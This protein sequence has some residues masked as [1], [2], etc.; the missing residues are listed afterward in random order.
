M[1]PMNTHR[2]PSLRTQKA[3]NNNR[4]SKSIAIQRKNTSAAEGGEANEN[5]DPTD[6]DFATWRMYNRIINHRR[7]HP[8]PSTTKP[9]IR[10]GG[11]HYSSSR[12]LRYD[13]NARPL[14]QDREE[15]ERDDGWDSSRG[16]EADEE[17]IFEM[18]L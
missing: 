18:D 17:G 10:L 4:R 15:E 14:G 8:L 3:N 7:V 12:T 2:Q 6:Y 16:S 13:L 11:R 5:V 9:E 1:Y